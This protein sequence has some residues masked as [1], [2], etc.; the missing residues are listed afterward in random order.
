MILLNL[1]KGKDFGVSYSIANCSYNRAYSLYS[2]IGSSFT[3]KKKQPLL[4]WR[5]N[6]CL[7]NNY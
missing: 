7:I 4:V 6:G 5:L 3:T 2:S 1:K